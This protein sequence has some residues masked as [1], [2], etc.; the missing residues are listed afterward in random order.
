MEYA[1]KGVGNTALGLSIGAL[2][3]ELLNGGLGGL[4]GNVGG[5]TAAAD[6]AAMMAPVMGAYTALAM[7]GAER[8]LQKWMKH[9]A[10][11]M[12]NLQD[13]SGLLNLDRVRSAVMPMMENE[14]IELALPLIGTFRLDRNDIDELFRY[15]QEG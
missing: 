13:E 7:D 11:A 3:V 2:G 14:K 10:I 4:L 5:R 1:S 6:T 12:L 8:E 15:V 9:P